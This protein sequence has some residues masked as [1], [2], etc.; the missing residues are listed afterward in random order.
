MRPR[1]SKAAAAQPPNPPK[2]IGSEPLLPPAD[3]FID[4]SPPYATVL[5]SLLLRSQHPF[6]QQVW[7]LLQ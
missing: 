4:V 1:G 5:A 2:L 6:Y 3:F 7:F